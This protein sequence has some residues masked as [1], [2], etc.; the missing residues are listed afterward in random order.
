[1]LLFLSIVWLQVIAVLKFAA[2]GGYNLESIS[3]KI[4]IK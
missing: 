1:M 2:V 4:G 3:E